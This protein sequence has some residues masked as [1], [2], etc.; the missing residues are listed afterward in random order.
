MAYA[1]LTNNTRE[2]ALRSMCTVSS[3]IIESLIDRP[4]VVYFDMNVW[5]SMTK[6]Y[7]SR[8]PRWEAVKA[9]MQGA[10]SAG[11]IV[12]PLSAAHYLDLWH[13]R[14]QRS[15][16]QVGVLMRDLS[17]YVAIKPTYWVRYHEVRAQISR[18]M[19]FRAR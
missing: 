19:G 9:S 5:V 3:S 4:L 12:I 10:V 16:E 15:R 6:G 13:R 8:N 1:M 11:R 7:V 14:D 17:Q 2:L 18:I